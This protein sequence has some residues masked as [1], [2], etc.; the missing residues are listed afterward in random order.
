MSTSPPTSPPPS[1][2]PAPA[3]TLGHVVYQDGDEEDMSLPELLAHLL[4]TSARPALST[5]QRAAFLTAPPPSTPPAPP[6]P[7]PIS[8][9]VPSSTNLAHHQLRL[10]SPL[11]ST[12]RSPP[13]FIASPAW[14]PR[15]DSHALYTMAP[16]SSRTARH[17]IWLP[18]PLS[19]IHPPP[20]PLSYDTI[21]R[22][23]VP[24]PDSHQPSSPPATPPAPSPAVLLLSPSP[25]PSPVYL[26]PLR[27]PAQDGVEL[28]P[29]PPCRRAP[30]RGGHRAPHPRRRLAVTPPPAP[31]G[32]PPL[33]P[34]RTRRGWGIRVV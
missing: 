11:L 1:P 23:C 28:P 16:S 20:S 24:T 17:S 12:P 10:C 32:S 6:L 29:P 5:P 14:I 2:A 18:H 15:H 7:P 30:W 33:P 31:R 26:P 9:H 13:C 34:S 4:P 27:R 25:P 19:T 21:F 8:L 3:D 22:E